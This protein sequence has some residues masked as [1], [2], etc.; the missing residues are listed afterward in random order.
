MFAWGYDV[1]QAES[2]NS[3]LALMEASPAD[4][5]VVDLTM[6][7]HGGLWLME[8]IQERWPGTSFIVAS[9]AQEETTIRSAKRLGAIAFVPKPF[10]QELIY[11]AL[12]QA[13][14]S[15]QPPDIPSR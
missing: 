13:L 3:A 5:V 15:R 9:G 6:P 14:R 7:V 2:A 12:E 4:I 10:G 1:L 8:R 11:Q